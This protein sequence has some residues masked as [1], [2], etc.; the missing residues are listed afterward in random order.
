[1][2]YAADEKTADAARTF[3]EAV[4]RMREAVA[5]FVNGDIGPRTRICSHADDTSLCGG[6]GGWERGWSQLEPRYAWAAAQFISADVAIEDVAR[7]VDGGLGYTA[8]IER[9]RAALRGLEGAAPVAPRVT[10]VYRNESGAW[11]MVH[12]HADPIVATHGAEAVI[13]PPELATCGY[14]VMG[15]FELRSRNWTE[16]RL[17]IFM[18]LIFNG[19]GLV[20][21]VANFVEGG[22]ILLPLVVLV[23]T[24]IVTPA[25]AIA[26]RRFGFGSS[27]ED[28]PQ[29][30]VA[31][32]SS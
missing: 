2:I 31:S 13:Q 8:W 19:A 10:H 25:A 17:P 27:V 22:P 7:Y 12:R 24:L 28:P 11:R 1:M 32:A 14:A 6:C 29:V 3:E 5:G 4:A 15:L 16:M 20:A 9:S 23:A 18:A 21:T 26:L 30:R